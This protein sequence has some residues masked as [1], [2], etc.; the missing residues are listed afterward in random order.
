[1]HQDNAFMTAFRGS[2]TSAL[3]WTQ[4]NAL[5]ARLDTLADQGWYIYAVGEPPPQAPATAAE[6]RRVVRELDSLLRRDHDEDYCGIVYADDPEQPR[7]V[8]IYDPNNLGVACGAS[9][10]PPL[11]G[12]ILSQLPPIDLPAALP[13]PAARRR[14]WRRLLGH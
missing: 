6:L 9:V 13:P 4:L 2:F 7:F 3:R 11:P 5:W 10:A 14:W 12:W 1:M 8:K